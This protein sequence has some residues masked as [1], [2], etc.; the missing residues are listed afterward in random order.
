[1]IE[2]EAYPCPRC[3]GV[4]L[5]KK[6]ALRKK[7]RHWECKQCKGVMLNVDDINKLPFIGS[8]IIKKH[9]LEKFLGSGDIGALRC[10]SCS[11]K[12]NEIH[13]VCKK[14]DEHTHPVEKAAEITAMG[15]LL[16]LAMIFPPAG[17][18]LNEMSKEEQKKNLYNREVEI[19][20]I[21][22]CSSCCSFWFDKGEL[23]RLNR[24]K[25][26]K[27]Y[28]GMNNYDLKQ[29][30]IDAEKNYTDLVG[31]TSKETKI[32]WG[33][34][35]SPNTKPTG[36]KSLPEGKIVGKVIEKNSPSEGLMIYNEETKKWDF[37]P[38]SK[39]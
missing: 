9:N 1:M 5:T 26:L 25:I 13:I 20:T 15:F 4:N 39:D 24:A 33:K 21:D 29:F 27:K 8:R 7:F 38:N 19:I 2:S 12:M 36:K 30:Q 16:L 11:S 14:N 34:V 23:R 10:G 22:G 17:L 37:V 6:F 32:E 31:F 35:S 28:S 3:S 18:I